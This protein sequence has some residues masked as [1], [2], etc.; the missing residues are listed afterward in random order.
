LTRTQ[1][2]IQSPIAFAVTMADSWAWWTGKLLLRMGGKMALNFTAPGL[3]SVVEFGQ[4]AIDF[5]RGDILGGLINT[6]S[7]IAD[8]VSLGTISN[9]KDAMKGS[10]TKAFVQTAKETGKEAAKSGGKAATKEVGR[11][12]AKEFSRGVVGKTVDEVLHQGTK[13]TFETVGHKG[14]IELISSGGCL[15]TFSQEFSSSV[16]ND[17]LTEGVEE[18]LKGSAS[19]ELVFELSQKAVKTAAEEELKKN[20]F[21][22]IAKD[23]CFAFLKG[24]VRCSMNGNHDERQPH[25]LWLFEL[26]NNSL[27]VIR[28]NQNRSG[29]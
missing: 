29:K 2:E 16:L 3:G 19:K 6:I 5:S 10:A 20:W 7:G 4:A 14:I 21:K 13:L 23:W 11:Q 26:N 28:N 17:F 24:G 8:V 18:I 22:W 25:H 1:E 27:V 12:F 15:K 9:I